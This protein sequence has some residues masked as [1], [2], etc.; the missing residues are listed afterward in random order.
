M[1][2]PVF[3]M[4]K[5]RLQTDWIRMRRRLTLKHALND[6]M[7]FLILDELQ[8][9]ILENACYSNKADDNIGRRHNLPD[10]VTLVKRGPRHN[11]YW[12]F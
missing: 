6:K 5:S 10:S 4:Y 1:P 11:V 7:L 2:V 9:K 3:Y 12:C 8:E